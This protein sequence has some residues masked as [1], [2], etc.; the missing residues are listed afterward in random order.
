M[1]TDVLPNVY[2]VRRRV[3]PFLGLLPFLSGKYL[4]PC[5]CNRRFQ[6]SWNL[7]FRPVDWRRLRWF[8]LSLGPEPYE[9]KT[10]RVEHDRHR[11]GILN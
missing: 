10:T 7:H 1:P 5:I 3:L 2:P 8:S 9:R 11:S 6:R 4:R